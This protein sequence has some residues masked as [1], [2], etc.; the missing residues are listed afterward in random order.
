MKTIDEQIKA[1]KREQALRKRVYPKLVKDGKMT[2]DE[3]RHEIEC[4]EEIVKTLEAEP[5]QR[6]FIL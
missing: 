3:A 1:A 6:K 2:A 5:E 4:M